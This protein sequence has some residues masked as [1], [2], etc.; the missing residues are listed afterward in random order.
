MAAEVIATELSLEIYKIDVSQIVS[1]Y[2][3]E[4]EKNLSR[5]FL[6]KRRPRTPFSSS[7][8]RMPCSAS[9]PRSRMRMTGMRM[10][11]SATCCRRWRS[12]REL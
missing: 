4:T 11:R 3:G 6:M 12:T 5:I 10:W 7:T 1:K 9:A 2:I 8:K